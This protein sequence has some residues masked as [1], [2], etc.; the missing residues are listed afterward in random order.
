MNARRSPDCYSGLIVRAPAAGTRRRRR[1][2]RRRTPRGDWDTG[3]TAPPLSYHRTTGTQA[4]PHE[5]GLTPVAGPYAP[6]SP[7]GPFRPLAGRTIVREPRRRE[8]TSDSAVGEDDVGRSV[9]CP[10][11]LEAGRPQPTLDA[12]APRSTPSTHTL[13][14]A[15][16]P[17]PRDTAGWSAGSRSPALLPA[18]PAIPLLAWPQVPNPQ[19]AWVGDIPMRGVIPQP[20]LTRVA[21]PTA[22]SG[23]SHI[24]GEWH[25]CW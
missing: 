16:G 20:P 25:I 22:R 9:R 21:T 23:L 13:M 24:S 12:A 18:A 3:H 11:R 4:T 14:T 2:S 6:S 7:V 15:G 10:G 1:Q 19:G 17:F 5:V 8:R